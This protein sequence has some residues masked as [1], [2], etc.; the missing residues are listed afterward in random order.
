MGLASVCGMKPDHLSR[1]PTPGKVFRHGWTVI[2]PLLAAGCATERSV[3]VGTPGPDQPVAIAPTFPTKR[4]DTR[5]VVRA[6]CDPADPAIRH[7]AHAVFRSSLVSFTA[8]D[9]LVTVPRERYPTVANRPLP[10][11]DELAAELGV[12]KAITSNLRAIQSAMVETEHRVKEEYATLVQESGAAL[13]IREQLEAERSRMRG[14][15]ST[16]AV[17]GSSGAAAENSAEAKW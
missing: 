1:V 6:Y 16:G 4:V 8:G 17:A 14:V 11:S 2:V 7:E 10:A 5:Y 12:Q 3:T 15:P 13:K 9:E